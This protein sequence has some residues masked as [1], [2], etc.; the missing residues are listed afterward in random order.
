MY[1]I[2]V[3]AH[4]SAISDADLGVARRE[5]FDSRRDRAGVGHLAP[6]EPAEQPL[7]ARE[8]AKAAPGG[9]EGYQNKRHDCPDGWSCF[10]CACWF[11]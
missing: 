3:V 8:W 1:R 6:E 2:E 9:E 4:P 10:F 5:L 11:H 7:A